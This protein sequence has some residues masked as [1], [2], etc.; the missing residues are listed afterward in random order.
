MRRI[1]SG[2]STKLLDDTARSTRASASRAPPVGSS[3]AAGS[4][5]SVASALTVRSRIAEIGLDRA[6]AQRGDVHVPGAIRSDRPPGPEL[7]RELERKAAGGVG[8]RAG[9]RAGITVDRE[10]EVDHLAAE[11]RVAHRAADD[12]RGRPGQRL[13]RGRSRGRPVDPVADSAHERSSRGTRDEIPQV[14]S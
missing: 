2:S 3:V 6:A 9:R 14:T 5:S 10:V 8:H 7:V 1:R 13:A 11:Q 4:A 12:P